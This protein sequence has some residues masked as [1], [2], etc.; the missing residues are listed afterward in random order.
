MT[1]NKLT[2]G[3]II[4]TRNGNRYIVVNDVLM[5]QEGYINKSD[6]NDNLKI[7]GFDEFDVM[8]VYDSINTL[9]LDDADVI[10][11]ERKENPKPKIGDIYI[12]EMDGEKFI[13]FDINEESSYPY[14]TINI[15]DNSVS[16][17]CYDEAEL[18]EY[19]FIENDMN[20]VRDFS[21]LFEKLKKAH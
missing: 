13:I 15:C 19:K 2:N 18:S 20:L 9:N 12:D 17:T 3:M 6:Y 8:K 10:L 14:I 21:L 5:R 1:K 4:E 16:G 7:S 11:W